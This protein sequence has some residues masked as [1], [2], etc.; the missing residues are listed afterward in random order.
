MANPPL[1]CQSRQLQGLCAE[2][3][4][5]GP[6]APFERNLP[7]HCSQRDTN[8]RFRNINLDRPFIQRCM[9]LPKGTI[10][11]D[12]ESSKE[13]SPSTQIETTEEVTF[14]FLVK[15]LSDSLPFVISSLER[16]NPITLSIAKMEK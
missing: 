9:N 5:W 7:L 14:P 4:R 16:P 13:T 11:S 1:S 10:T 15:P 3:E 2:L 6:L 12:I 8:I